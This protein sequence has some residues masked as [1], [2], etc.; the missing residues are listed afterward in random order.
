MT[1]PLSPGDL[2][3]II[4]SRDGLSIGKI[5]ECV[6]IDFVGHPEFG[7]IWLVKSSRADLVT[8]YGGV[9]DNFHVPATWLKRIPNEPLHEQNPYSLQDHLETMYDGAV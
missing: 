8:E 2:A 4:K 9:G 6:Q 5:V 7:T 1:K 3:I